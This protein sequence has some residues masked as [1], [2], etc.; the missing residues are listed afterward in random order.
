MIRLIF[1]TDF[2]E[3]FAY[4]LLRGIL[5]YSKQTRQ[6][7]VCRMPPAYK[8]EEG[9]EGRA[10]SEELREFKKRKKK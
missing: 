6:W 1:L 3:S 8:R 9:I 2:T 4:C 7:A 5:K 10:K